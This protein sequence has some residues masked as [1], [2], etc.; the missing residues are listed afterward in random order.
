MQRRMCI[1][2][3]TRLKQ[4]EWDGFKVTIIYNT[5]KREILFVSLHFVA[6]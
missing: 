2:S 4:L 6:M 5:I 3:S 1:V